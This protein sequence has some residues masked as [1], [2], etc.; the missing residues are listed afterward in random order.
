M[1]PQGGCACS[2][3]LL[4]K[5]SSREREERVRRSCG[6]PLAAGCAGESETYP[7]STAVTEL[8]HMHSATT[9]EASPRVRRISRVWSHTRASSLPHGRA[10]RPYTLPANSPLSLLGGAEEGGLPRSSMLEDEMGNPVTVNS[11]QNKLV[12]PRSRPRSRRFCWRLV[13]GLGLG[14]GVGLG[15]A[16]TSWCV[17]ANVTVEGGH[18]AGTA[19]FWWRLVWPLSKFLARAQPARA[20]QSTSVGGGLRVIRPLRGGDE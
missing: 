20:G 13:L 17:E 14:L 7:D 11:L 12:R 5:Q 18:S 15:K 9:S 2:P 3:S 8:L 4:H 16:R 1:G 10:M 6:V 19:V